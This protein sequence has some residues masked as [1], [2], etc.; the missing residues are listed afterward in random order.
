VDVSVVVLPDLA[1]AD[2]VAAARDAEAAG[3]RT[4]W[5]YDHLSWRD[6]RDGPWYAAMPLLTAVAG[7]TSTVR[8]G[9]FVAS[10]N[11]RHPIPFAKEVMTVDAISGGRFELGI[12]SGG[13]GADATVLGQPLGTPGE[14][15]ERFVEWVEVLRGSLASQR[16]SFE[17]SCFSADDARMIPSAGHVPVTIAAAGP[18]ALR[19]AARSADAWVTYGPIGSDGSPAAWLAGVAEQAAVIGDAPIRR[20]VSIGLDERWAVAS[21]EAYD[22]V[23]GELTGLGFDEVV[24]HWPRADGRGVPAAALD[25]VLARHS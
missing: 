10:P 5:T 22:E 12:G 3:V 2:V 13:T 9:T 17:G 20:L 4:V 18:R 21:G 24:L 7:A 16:F 23:L 6:L 15:F 25:E 11:F 8:M 1:P 19:F 14:R